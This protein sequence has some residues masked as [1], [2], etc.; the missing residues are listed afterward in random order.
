[1]VDAKKMLTQHKLQLDHS[2]LDAVVLEDKLVVL[3]DSD[4]EREGQFHNLVALSF[5]GEPLWSAEFP[6]IE[7]DDYYYRMI[8][9]T[10][11]RAFSVSL[12]ECE[13]DIRTGRI[14]KKTP[15]KGGDS[16]S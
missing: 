4:A 7:K 12:Y 5:A 2:I 16:G 14:C 11:L 10:S 1:M 8:C 13:I 15:I 3:L 6:T 9:D